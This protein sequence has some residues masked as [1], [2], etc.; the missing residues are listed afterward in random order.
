MKNL[1]LKDFEKA[2]CS[3][4]YSNDNLFVKRDFSSKSR[5]KNYSN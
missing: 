5:V 3:E 1:K 2:K 4:K